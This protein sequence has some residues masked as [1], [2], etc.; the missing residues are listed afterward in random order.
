MDDKWIV[1]IDLSADGLTII[2]THEEVILIRAGKLLRI[3]QHRI[4]HN[5]ARFKFAYAVLIEN[6]LTTP[7]NGVFF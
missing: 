3:S 7:I 6:S 1:T 2:P 5:R 4:G